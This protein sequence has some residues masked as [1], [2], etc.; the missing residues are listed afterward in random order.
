MYSHLWLHCLD[1]VTIALFVW[2]AIAESTGS[3]SGY[4]GSKDA[5]YAVR[6]WL[7]MTLR[8]TC[9]LMVASI[10]LLHV[11]MGRSVSFG[12]KHW[13][14][15]AP[16][17]VLAVTS[18]GV[19]GVLAGARTTTLFL[20]L[21]TYSTTIAA[22]TSIAFVCLVG[23][24]VVIKRNLAVAN[25]DAEPWPP[26]KNVD[27]KPRPSFASEDVEEMRDGASWITSNASSHRKS[28]S[29]WSFSTH[30]TTV[31]SHHGHG[32]PQ[33]PS[34][35]SVPGKSSYWFGGST[36]SIPPVPTLPAPYGP[37]SPTAES[38]RDE[39][40][41]RRCA[42]P[43]VDD[44]DELGVPQRPRMGSQT[45][46]LTSINGSEVALSAWSYPTTQARDGSMRNASSPNINT[47]LLPSTAVSR[48]NTPAMASAQVLGGYG[49]NDSERGLSALAAPGTSV[50]ISVYRALG[51]LF[52]IWIPLVR[53]LFHE[54]SRI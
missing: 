7:V 31:P 40:P 15:W 28:L 9:L 29:N 8:Q 16:T 37:L 19:A 48:P 43:V 50:D 30:H 20:G 51:W 14:L 38:M 53:F 39:D 12:T 34:H 46:W 33:G 10:T 54:K 41:F 23:T 4:E 17:F 52:A 5:A 49:Q 25:E 22:F 35:P 2:Q 47:E 24:L 45:S 36:T 6:L 21:I 26:A 1:L 11:R 44:D 13:V 42:T 18:T 32:R 27:E 3:V